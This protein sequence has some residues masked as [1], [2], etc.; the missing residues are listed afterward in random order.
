MKMYLIILIQNLYI[1][2]DCKKV[3]ELLYTDSTTYLDIKYQEY[4][5]IKNKE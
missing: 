3:L 4:L 2:E 5:K 1:G